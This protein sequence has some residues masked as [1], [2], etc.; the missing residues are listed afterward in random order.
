M[1]YVRLEQVRKEL[2]MSEGRANI[3]EL[4]R[5]HGFSSR[6]HF[7]KNY[8]ELFGEKPTETLYKFLL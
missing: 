8:N 2:L 7:A 5:R 4:A 1:R 6:G 3:G